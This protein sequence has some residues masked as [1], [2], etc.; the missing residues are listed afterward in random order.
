MSDCRQLLLEPCPPFCLDLTTWALRRRAHNSIDR[1][2]AH[3]Y[4]RVVSIDGGP[5]AISVSQNGV[6]GAPLLAVTLRG[7]PL[8]D[9]RSRS[10]L[11]PCTSSWG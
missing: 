2:N 1:W 6:T 5:V 4:H 7:R 8:A 11:G 10:R 9:A 3:T